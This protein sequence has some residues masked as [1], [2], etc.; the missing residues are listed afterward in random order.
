MLKN[1][2][3]LY[4]EFIIFFFIE[5]VLITGYFIFFR[6]SRNH[7]GVFDRRVEE[8]RLSVGRGNRNGFDRR[9]FNMGFRKMD[10]EF[11]ETNE[12]FEVDTERRINERRM[13]IDRRIV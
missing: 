2:F 6:F 4:E 13:V 9:V 10:V 8:R 1:L 12:I 11:A 7:G 5:I 3:P